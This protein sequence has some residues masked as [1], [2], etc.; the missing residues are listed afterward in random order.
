MSKHTIF[1][2]ET[3]KLTNDVEILK[4]EMNR[5]E[6]EID[7]CSTLVPGTIMIV[8][9]ILDEAYRKKNISEIDYNAGKRNVDNMADK[10]Y[11]RCDCRN[12]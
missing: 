1:G 10:F 11:R 9:W 3:P 4:R 5:L 6:K 7:N 2:H 12:R 8:E